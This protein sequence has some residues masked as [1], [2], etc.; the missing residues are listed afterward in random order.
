MKPEGKNNKD[1]FDEMIISAKRNSL[2]KEFLAKKVLFDHENGIMMVVLKGGQVVIED[3]RKYKA[4]SE[5]TKRDREKYTLLG[6][7]AAIHW[8]SLDEDLSVRK[9]I[10]DFV[11]NYQKMVNKAVDLIPVH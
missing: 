4:L 8:D 3:F 9:I 10:L 2:P 7:G 6:K 1:Y 5:A 11:K